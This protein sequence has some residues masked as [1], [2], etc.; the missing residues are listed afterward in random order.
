MLGEWE[1]GGSRQAVERERRC[2]CGYRFRHLHGSY[3]RFVVVGAAEFMIEIPRLLCPAC[4]RT[5]AV[6]PF[7]LASRS[8]YPWCLRQAAV[9]SFLGDG[10]GY[11]AIGAGFGLDWQLLWAWVD[12]LAGE[13]KAEL[14]ALTGLGLRYPGLFGPL[15][16]GTAPR[17]LDSHRARVRS[18]AK[19][20]ALAAIPVLLAAGYGLW[21][22]GFTLGVG[23]PRPD[24]DETLG[25]LAG[26]GSF[27][28]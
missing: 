17:R 19:Q 1:R 5:A 22:A 11:R 25:F 21:K 14:A 16:A 3:S 13:A 2:P 24:Q 9:V 26:L 28:A 20:E 4:G 23:W 27:L 10:G 6:R 12:T 15:P 18:P 7:F 8:P